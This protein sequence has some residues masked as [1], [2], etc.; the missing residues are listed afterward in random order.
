MNIKD[1]MNKKKSLAGERGYLRLFFFII[2]LSILNIL[3]VYLLYV[4]AIKPGKSTTKNT[5]EAITNVNIQSIQNIL[6]DQYKCENL[7]ISPE[8][9]VLDLQNNETTF[10]EI[11]KQSPKLFIRFTGAGCSGCI[12]N[13][14]K[15][16]D[17]I[18]KHFKSANR[19]DVVFFFS[20]GNVNELRALRNLYLI[21]SPMYLLKKG[22][23]PFIIENR[24][25]IVSF[26]F[27][28]L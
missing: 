8:I 6:L 27:Y 24:E 20:T 14:E 11:I 23:L 19:D 3:V 22:E 7:F 13:F 9:K 17:I 26:F 4:K 10:K 5:L 1:Y 16:L 2:I 25:D 15:E 18:R 12:D 28:R 21:N